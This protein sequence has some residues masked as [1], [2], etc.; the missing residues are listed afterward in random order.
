MGFLVLKYRIT[1]FFSPSPPNQRM[2]QQPGPLGLL[3]AN[4]CLERWPELD[5]ETEKTMA[6]AEQLIN[7]WHSNRPRDKAGLVSSFG[8]LCKTEEWKGFWNQQDEAQL[9]AANY[10]FLLNLRKELKR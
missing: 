1:S 4:A 5:L 10:F 3:F 9:V 6:E 2:E 8:L 7:N